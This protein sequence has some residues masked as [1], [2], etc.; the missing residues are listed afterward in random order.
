VTAWEGREGE[1]E[2]GFDTML[3]ALTLIRVGC[4][5]ILEKEYMG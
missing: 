3:E 1:R 2:T 4:V 5:Y